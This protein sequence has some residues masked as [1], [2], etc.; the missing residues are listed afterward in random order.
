MAPS[1]QEPPHCHLTNPSPEPSEG[2]LT[3]GRIR[4]QLRLLGPSELWSNGRE[5][6]LGGPSSARCSPCS[7]FGRTRW[8]AASGSS[9]CCGARTHPRAWRTGWTPRSRACARRYA[10]PEVTRVWSRRSTAATGCDW[11][12][13]SSTCSRR[14]G[15]SSRAGP[16]WR[17]AG[18]P[19]P[20]TGCVR[21]CASAWAGARRPR[22]RRR[23]AGRDTAPRGASARRARGSAGGRAHAGPPHGP[24]AGAQAAGRGASTARAAPG[25]ADA[26]ALPR[27]QGGRG[28]RGLP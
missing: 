20:W 4:V 5:I 25:P 2:T 11:T 16:P 24:R 14:S 19:R 3:A 23:L 28:A 26:R 21:R 15:S 1:L 18:H 8:S 27:R 6:S 22:G 17:T 12:E 10:T 13:P 9:R 7:A